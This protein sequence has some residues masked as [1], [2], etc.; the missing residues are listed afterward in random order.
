MVSVTF[1]TPGGG[2]KSGKL[3]SRPS[4]KLSFLKSLQKT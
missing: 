3:P 2:K 1:H 4:A